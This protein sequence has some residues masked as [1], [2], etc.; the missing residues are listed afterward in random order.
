MN[1]FRWILF[2]IAGAGAL[3]ALAYLI[4]LWLDWNDV[5]N[6]MTEDLA[7]AWNSKFRQSFGLCLSLFCVTGFALTPATNQ[8]L[9][10]LFVLAIALIGDW[11]VFKMFTDRFRADLQVARKKKEEDDAAFES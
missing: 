11:K 10:F 6:S 8:F 5:R 2:F 7:A 1:V 4:R 9:R 3:G